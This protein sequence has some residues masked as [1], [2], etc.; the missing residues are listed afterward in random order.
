[1]LGWQRYNQEDTGANGSIG[2]DFGTGGANMTLLESRNLKKVVSNWV[3][4][5]VRKACKWR[6]PSA[7]MSQA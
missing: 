6:N 2:S 1:M 7:G 5:C 3:L 4:P